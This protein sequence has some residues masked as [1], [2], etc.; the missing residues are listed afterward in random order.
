MSVDV[1]ALAINYL[2]ATESEQLTAHFRKE[3][4]PVNAEVGLFIE[5]LHL[6]YNAKPAKGYAAFV[7]RSDTG[8]ADSLGRW[9]QQEQPFLAL[10][11]QATAQLVVQLN[12]HQ[13]QESGYFLLCHYRYLASE[14]VLIT[15]LGSKE[16]F[17]VAA[18]LSLSSAKHL[19]IAR[20]QLAARLDLT[21]YAT[22]AEQGKYISFIRGRAGRKVA[23]FFM[24]FLGC[25]ETVDVKANSKVM[26]ASVEE[27]LAAA[28]YDAAE[29]QDVR[30][31]V[32]QYCDEQTKNGQEIS[33]QALS[34]TVDSSDERAFTRFCQ[35]R[36]IP[37]AE[38]FAVEVK[39][40]KTLVKFA[41]S[42]GGVSINFEQ[43]LL[44]DRIRYDATTD[45]LVI[46][47]TPPNLRDQLQ[48]HV[49]GYSTV[50]PDGPH[51]SE[52]T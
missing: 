39:E 1:L 26:L 44:G 30:K 48:K 41:G 51:K 46:R 32:F 27:Y 16:H 23:D 19:D 31:Q 14:Y 37:V 22:A 4:V 13:I 50:A 8:F 25:E 36:D 10:A 43:K 35:E 2:Q 38:Q 40:L 12:Q 18:D 42:G 47:G 21:D 34:A 20:M 28:D 52:L 7:T 33:L 15:L 17:S 29:K 3:L 11:E 5:Q 49:L 6:G 9:Q 24:D 45:T